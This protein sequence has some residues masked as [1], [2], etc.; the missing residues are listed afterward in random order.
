M[1]PQSIPEAAAS[2]EGP[3]TKRPRQGKRLRNNEK[4]DAECGVC[5][6]AANLTNDDN[7]KSGGS[8]TSSV[9]GTLLASILALACS[10]NNRQ[11]Q[12]W[13]QVPKWCFLQTISTLIARLPMQPVFM[14]NPSST[15]GDAPA[16]CHPFLTC[17]HG[18]TTH[19]VSR[20]NV[21]HFD[22]NAE[23]MHS[24]HHG[25]FAQTN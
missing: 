24:C 25:T 5:R 6:G 21:C 18:P 22:G 1:N 15:M 16:A 23:R 13:V 8:L 10:G 20:R 12:S 2:S 7:Q 9:D 17:A 14:P 19:T 11:T 4:I 3:S